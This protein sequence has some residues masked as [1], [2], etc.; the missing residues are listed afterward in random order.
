MLR[1]YRNV[2]K[3]ILKQIKLKFIPF[4]VVTSGFLL[5]TLHNV[6]AETLL[7]KGNIRNHGY[8]TKEQ[9]DL[10]GGGLSD[11][12]EFLS[13]WEEIGEFIQKII[14]FFN[15]LPE[16]LPQ[17]TINLLAKTYEIMSSTVLQTPLFIFNNSYL[18][19]TS[20]V[21]A[22]IS[23]LIV[24]IL[25]MFEGIKQMLKKK[26][27]DLVKISKR[28]ILAILGAG[29][30]PFLFEKTFYLLNTLSDAIAKIGSSEMA[31]FQMF[32]SIP[33]LTG[34]NISFLVIFDLIVVALLIPIILQTARRWWD[35][36]CLSVLTP[37]SLTAWIF[38]DYRHLFHRWWGNVKLLSQ[39][40]IVYAIYICLMGVFIFGTQNIA[41]GG[42]LL[43]KLLIITGGLFRMCNIPTFVKNRV[44][45]GNDIKGTF[46]DITKTFKTVKTTL[47]RPTDLIKQ[48]LTTRKEKQESELAKAQAQAEQQKA[49]EKK[50]K[51]KEY[52]DMNKYF[53]RDK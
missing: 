19:D 44:D 28:Y 39:T 43:L 4:S 49:I 10:R 29:F 8:F 20:L 27:T 53:R 50:Q 5:T 24:T 52:K 36:L 47:T 22:G 14:H 45:D 48:Q 41:T 46:Y 26:H 35:I 33:A 23:M 21:F 34:L 25:T 42:G 16:N 1:Q 18:Q 37:L 17:Y 9:M 13:K 6:K 32:H 2:S 38:D 40:Q 51:S 3:A 15:H 30:A 7:E 31:N 11:F 12:K